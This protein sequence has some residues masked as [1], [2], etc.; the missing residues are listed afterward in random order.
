MIN[1]AQLAAAQ[2]GFQ[3]VFNE[4]KEGFVD[5]V[6]DLALQV[7]STNKIEDYAWIDFVPTLK[8]WVGD[9]KVT[10]LAADG[11]QVT[12]KDYAIGV[13]VPREDF[14]SDRY[15]RV[16]AKIAGMAK[17]GMRHPGQLVANLL[18]NA[19][20]TTLGTSY[21]GLALI[22]GSHVWNG[23]TYSNAGTAALAVASFDAAVA[24][25][26]SIVDEN[27]DSIG[28][29][30]RALVVG[31]SLKRT[32]REIV[33]AQ[34]IPN[35]AGTASKT[36][37]LQNEMQVIESS[38]LVGAYANFW[39]LVDTDNLMAPFILQ[40]RE[41][42]SFVAMDMP[43]SENLYRRNALEYGVQWNGAA[44]YGFWQGIWGSNG[45]T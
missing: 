38:A 8:E 20:A 43:T 42:L 45:T 25:M 35:T 15:G 9:R 33:N 27:G 19:R 3:T 23:S 5:P 41:P 6:L 16:S 12:N 24:A 21:D 22:S 14:R 26:E 1:N 18:K 10:R 44:A 36:N 34:I 28:M 13:E 7:N 11:F 31:P 39:F 29:K 17:Q 2:I 40:V 4:V 30:A 37:V 32:A